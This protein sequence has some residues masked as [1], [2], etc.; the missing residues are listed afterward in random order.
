[1]S[2]WQDRC[3][4]H[5]VLVNWSAWHGRWDHI[6]LVGPAVGVSDERDAEISTVRTWGLAGPPYRC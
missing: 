2:C 3:R 5:S 1:M 6:P 4:E